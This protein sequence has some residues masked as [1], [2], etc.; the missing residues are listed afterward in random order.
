MCDIISDS[1]YGYDPRTWEQAKFEAIRVIVGQAGPIFYSE[2]AKRVRTIAFDPH[3]FS[4]HHLLGQIST[5]EDAAGRGMLS[6]LVVRQADGMPGQGFFDLAERLGRD[7][8]DRERC[9]ADETRSVLNHRH[10]HPLAA[11]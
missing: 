5:E 2:L 1:T 8:S 10:N 7:V 3:D 11:A 6:V 4:F 9:W